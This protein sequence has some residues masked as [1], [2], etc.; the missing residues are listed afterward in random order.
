MSFAAIATLNESL[1][2]SGRGLFYLAAYPAIAPTGA[3]W[4]AKARVLFDLFLASTKWDTLASGVVPFAN[5]NTNGLDVKAK[6]NMLEWESNVDAKED[7]AIIDE[8]LTAEFTFADGDPKHLA[9]LFNAAAD[10]LVSVAAATGTPGYDLLGLGGQQ[11]L[12]DLVALYMIEDQQFPGQYEMFLFP[13][14][15]SNIDADW[16]F[17]KKSVVETKAMIRA[18]GDYNIL[19]ARNKPYKC[20]HFK[21]TAAAL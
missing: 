11:S 4:Q 14:V 8:D 21:P 18:K 3:D 16:K 2:R 12:Q 19:N 6:Q 1:K 13:K 7:V 9:T 10:D 15:S 5:L 20:F 17:S